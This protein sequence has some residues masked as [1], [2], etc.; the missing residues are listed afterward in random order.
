MDRLF[1]IKELIKKCN[2]EELNKVMEVLQK[3]YF[4]PVIKSKKELLKEVNYTGY[5]KLEKKVMDILQ[6]I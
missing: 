2:D 4:I 6:N 1:Y 5:H 3:L